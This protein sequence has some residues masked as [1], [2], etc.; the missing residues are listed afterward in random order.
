LI[1]TIAMRAA[2]NSSAAV[3]CDCVRIGHTRSLTYRVRYWVFTVADALIS[4]A[5]VSQ[6]GLQR[7][8]H[9]SSLFA[10]TA[11]CSCVLL[12]FGNCWCH[13]KIDCQSVRKVHFPSVCINS[14]T[15]CHSRFFWAWSKHTIYSISFISH[16][17]S[18]A[19]RLPRLALLC[20]VF[21]ARY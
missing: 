21:V 1:E 11:N 17:W 9:S 4:S 14:Q 13:C 19:V 10:Q 20:V 8:M 18:F 3:S 12:H 15:D 7:A 5:P 6:F 16:H 2:W